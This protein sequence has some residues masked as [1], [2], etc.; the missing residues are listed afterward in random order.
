MINCA[1]YKGR[2][3]VFSDL[4]RP[5]VPG[6]SARV[7]LLPAVPELQHQPVRFAFNRPVRASVKDIEVRQHNRAGWHHEPLRPVRPA[8]LRHSFL[9]ALG[10]LSAFRFL[11]SLP[12]N[13]GAALTEEGAADGRPL[14]VRRGH[15]AVVR[16]ELRVR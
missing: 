16:E 15:V 5:V 11:R 8:Q 4:S 7:V 13:A 3:I 9:V 14:R 12:C 1:Y 2:K 10:A 6:G